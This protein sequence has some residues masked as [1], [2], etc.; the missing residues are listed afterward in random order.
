MKTPK[1]L[2]QIKQY[3]D[4]DIKTQ[5]KQEKDILKVIHKLKKKQ[6]SYKEKLSSTEQKEKRKKLIRDI[7]IIKAQ[8]KKGL[9]ALKKARIKRK[10]R[11]TK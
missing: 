3:L 5:L 10:S 2:K 9:K 8:R 6:V 1:L 4:S 7:E 11:K